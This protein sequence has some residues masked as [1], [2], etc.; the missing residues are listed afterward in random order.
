MGWAHASTDRPVA[1]RYRLVEITH[2]ETNRVSWYA[3]DLRTGRPC[4]ATRIELPADAAEDV[5]R[6]PSRIVRATGNVARLC[7]DRIADVVDAVGEGGCLWTVTAWIDGTPLDEVLLQRG[8]FAP[9]RA[10]RVALDLLDVLDAAHAEA[11]THG[12]LSPGQ[13]HLRETGPVI[14]SGYGVAGTTSAPRLTA[15][16]YAAPEQ[17]RNE[18]VGPA[19]DLWALGAILYTMLEGRPPFRDRGRVAATLRGVERLPLR[20]PLRCGP[21]TQLVTGLLRKEPRERPGRQ[22]VREVLT[23]VLSEAPGAGLEPGE[24]YAPAGRGWKRKSVLVGTPLAVLTVT[25]AVVTAATG[26]PGGDDRA[27]GGSPASAS[28]SA[29]GTGAADTA[30]RVPPSS[31]APS[32]PPS[33]SPTGSASPS[34]SGSASPSPSDPGALPAGFRTY[35]APEG[36]SVAL[37]EGWER[38]RTSRATELS[39]RVTFGADDDPR[40]LAVTYSERVGSDPVAVWQDT[41]EPGLA[42]ADAYR[43]IGAIEAT[44]YQG[45]E[46]ADM[47][48]ITTDGGTRVRTFGRGFLLGDGRGF[49]LRWTTPAADWASADSQEALRTVLRTFRPGSAS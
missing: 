41:V 17:A 49:S 18:R 37:P 46:A 34:P 11:V 8:T 28:A 24:A 10:A 22:V 48:W 26:L 19:A 7:P 12:E 16:S 30:P 25:A 31:K 36:F 20:P 2:R 9:A 44:T 40:T 38:Q 42:R 23:R 39:Y 4:L 47:E 13:L 27:G 5:R 15:P 29:G 45:R 6:A 3:D 35:R 33:P 21:L 43:R 14:V 1:G 32:S